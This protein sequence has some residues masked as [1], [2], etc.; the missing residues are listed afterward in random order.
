[1]ATVDT[2]NGING[3]KTT[4]GFSA[5]GTAPFTI[6]GNLQEVPDIGGKLDKIESTTLADTQKT[7]VAGLLDPGDLAFKF[8]YDTATYQTAKGL[9]GTTTTLQVQYPD[10]STQ[11]FTAQLANV[12]DAVKTGALVTFTMN[13][14]VL[15]KI[16]YAAPSGS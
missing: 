3:Q 8:R 10:G 12:M 1:M 6:L 11:T 14:V 2:T 15:S 4:V 7:Y 5:T 9:E 16:N 13:V